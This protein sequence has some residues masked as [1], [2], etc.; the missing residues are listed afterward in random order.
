MTFVKFHKEKKHEGRASLFT[1]P[2]SE[3]KASPQPSQI[4]GKR[5]LWR[6][7]KRKSLFSSAHLL[8]RKLREVEEEEN[9]AGV[10]RELSR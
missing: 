1:W 7:K 4:E 8:A 10:F 9:N 6:R 3:S 5:E 2:F